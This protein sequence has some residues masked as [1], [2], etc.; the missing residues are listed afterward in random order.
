MKQLVENSAWN[1]ENKL[2][3]LQA[4]LY[5]LNHRHSMAELSYQASIVSA[6]EHKFFHEEALAC[7]LYGI[8]LIENKKLSKGMK[9]LKQALNKYKAWGATKKADSVK[10]FVYVVKKPAKLWNK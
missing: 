9:Q 3:L 1:F 7:E 5:Y 8:Y 6:H 4:E 2:C 10:D